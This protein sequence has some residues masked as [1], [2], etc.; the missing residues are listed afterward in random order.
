MVTRPARLPIRLRSTCSSPHCRAAPSCSKDTLAA[1]TSAARIG[2]G[3]PRRRAIAHG[4]SSRKPNTCAAPDW[5]KCS[6]RMARKYVNVT[7]AFW[8][9]RCTPAPGVLDFLEDRGVKLH[10]PELAALDRKSTRLNSSH[11]GISYAVFC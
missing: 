5:P 1:A 11:L 3:R 9:V 6:R 10:H 8:D 2:T 7:E 4:F